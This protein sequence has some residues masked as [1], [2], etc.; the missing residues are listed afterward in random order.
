MLKSVITEK[1]ILALI[2]IF[3]RFGIPI[4]LRTSQ[5]MGHNLSPTNLSN[6]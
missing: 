6:T 1:V 3:S 4:T 2:P 5:I